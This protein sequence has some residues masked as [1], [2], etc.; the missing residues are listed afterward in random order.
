MPMMNLTTSKEQLSSTTAWYRGRLLGALL[1]LIALAM[2]IA[3]KQVTLRI[4]L[5]PGEPEEIAVVTFDDDRISPA[6]VKR[7][8][9]LD[10]HAYYSEP[11][12]PASASCETPIPALEQEIVR[13]R[14]TLDDLDANKFPPELSG[15]VAYFK[16]SQ[17]LW[18][19][20]G[21][22]KLEF[23]K[24]NKAPETEYGGTDLSR[25]QVHPETLDRAQACHQVNYV[26]DN[27]VVQ[28]MT[29]EIG[30]YPTAQWKAFLD[31]YGIQ[32]RI[33][34]TIND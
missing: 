25:C 26:W 31:A 8:I 30:A 5:Q 13:A 2:P 18:L 16:N 28:K 14:Q 17:S 15:V 24:S 1:G 4:P 23:L 21:E 29:K 6:D 7:W 12:A 34:S 10:Q 33:E 11:S 32:E 19:W 20:I 3:A 9:L 22:Q 27:C